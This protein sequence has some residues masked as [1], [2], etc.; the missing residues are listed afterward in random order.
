M[1]LYGKST[2]GTTAH[3]GG[4]L[5]SGK[6]G[7]G[8]AQHFLTDT[9]GK[10]LI[11]TVDTVTNPVAIKWVDTN[12]VVNA[13]KN[14]DGNPRVVNQTYLEQI[15]EGNVTNHTPWSKVGF[16]PA[17]T[18]AMEDIW[19]AGGLYV[20]PTAATAMSVV[21]SSA[22]DEDLG[23]VLHSGATT[24]AGGTTTTIVVAGENFSTTTAIGDLIIIERAGT[25]PEWG[26]I[27]EVTSNTVLT[28]AGGLS[29]GGTGASRGTYDIID[30][31][32][33][34]GAHAVKID[35]LDATYAAKTEI[36][37]LNGDTAVAMTASPFRIN[38]FRAISCGSTGVAVG[39]LTLEASVGGQD[40]SYITA[41]YTR[42]R[43][44]MYTVPLGKTLYVNMW[45]VGAATNNDTKVQTCRIMT[46]A[47]RE[48][49][50]GFLSNCFYG[51]TEMLVT[52]E[53]GGIFFPIPTKLPAKTDIKV[54]AIG[55]T[56]FSGSVTSILRGWLE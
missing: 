1:S 39:N 2:D 48:P 32:A 38:S 12:G 13:F 20:Y 30:V 34:T 47:N 24:D 14:V 7:S 9:S 44:N 21:S 23:T 40:Y 4:T 11:G 56:G 55:L 18:T 37:I 27:T 53:N 16:N 26:Y 51:Y 49:A 8:N 22:G 52:N 50:T 15:A 3:G 10:P 19:S 42:A 28:F 33:K 46:R 36:V 43:N 25:T 41:G 31:S 6:D 5:I 35:Y 29:S 45:Q 54:S 17:I